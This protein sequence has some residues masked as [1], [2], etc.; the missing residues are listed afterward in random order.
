[1][2]DVQIEFRQNIGARNVQIVAQIL[3][4]KLEEV[5]QVVLTTNRPTTIQ[6][7]A[8]EYL[9]RARLPSGEMVRRHITAPTTTA[10][11]V[12][13]SHSPITSLALQQFLGHTGTSPTPISREIAATTWLR[14]WSWQKDEWKS[15]R[16][17]GDVPSGNSEAVVASLSLPTDRVWLLQIGGD[18]VPHRFIAV[19][20]SPEIELFIRGTGRNTVVNGGVVVCMASLDA[21]LEALV[22]YQHSGAAESAAVVGKQVVARIRE[23]L[24]AKEKDPNGAALGFYYLLSRQDLSGAEDWPQTFARLFPWL[25]DAAIIC[26]LQALQMEDVENESTRKDLAMEM[27]IRAGQ[28]AVPVYT[29]GLRSLVDFLET[30]K[31]DPGVAED[32][33]VDSA[34]ERLK[35]FAFAVDWG[36]ARTTFLGTSP[37]QPSADYVFG[38]ANSPDAIYLRVMPTA[39]APRR[40]QN[41]DQ[42][43]LS[44][45]EQA[46]RGVKAAFEQLYAL[47]HREVTGYLRARC[48]RHDADD[49]AQQLWMTVLDKIDQFDPQRANFAGFLKYRASIAALR[50]FHERNNVLGR[51]MLF[52]EMESRYG[53]SP[54]EPEIVEA[55]IAAQRNIETPEQRIETTERYSE[56]LRATFATPSPPHQLIS[57][58]YCKL[59]EWRPQELVK[60]SSNIS[61]GEMEIEFEKKYIE[62]IPAESDLVR[63]AL[64]RLRKSLDRCFSDVVSDPATVAM[65]PQL[66]SKRVGDTTLA[67]YYRDDPEQNVAHWVYAV[68][69]R[70]V[71]ALGRLRASE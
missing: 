9:L 23:Y 42:S 6:L 37:S 41:I 54:K 34:L 70:T 8:G 29:R 58:G 43:E 16:W 61:L 30:Y 62:H 47:H 57:F 40:R 63:G 15:E 27:L 66:S 59:L 20:P 56:L 31:A 45:V 46:R 4:T 28:A 1:M 3:N 21:Q 39:D 26:G 38:P 22:R 68:R 51:A 52:S 65:Y 11:V 19:P 14:L 60:E 64:S 53:E 12:S 71:A 33:V 10:I 2:S 50:W 25:P 13:T 24:G 17:P 36:E 44:L 18:F 49:I 7:E 5:D 55:A 48:T 67:Q 35:T 69:R 32:K